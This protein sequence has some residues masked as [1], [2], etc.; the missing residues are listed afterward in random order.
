MVIAVILPENDSIIQS[1]ITNFFANCYWS[2]SGYI[3][4]VDLIILEL[5]AFILHL[6]KTYTYLGCK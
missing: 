2:K 4:S 1:E 5:M 3:I 6:K